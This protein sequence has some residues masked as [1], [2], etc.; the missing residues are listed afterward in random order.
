[1]ARKEY[2]SSNERSR[3]DS[4]PQLENIR[5]LIEIPIWAENYLKTLFTSTNKTGFILQMGYF[6]VT[7]R[8][9]NPHLFYEHDIN[10][11][12]E[13]F[14][15]DPNDISMIDYAHSRTSYR[16]QEEILREFSITAFS[17]EYQALLYQE[18]KRLTYLQTKPTL[19]F[20]SLVCFLQEKRIEIPTYNALREIVTKALD[21]FAKDLE[22]IIQTYL[23]EIDRDL[24]EQLA[25]KQ[26][27]EFSEKKSGYERYELTFF[28]RITQS[29]QPMQIKERLELFIALKFKYQQLQSI[30]KKLK[31]SDATIRYLADYILDNQSSQA[32]KRVNEH[33]LQLIAFVIHQYFSLGD[34]LILTLNSAVTSTFN[35]AEDRLKE[36]HYKNRFVN[37]QLANQVTR[38]STTHID[39]LGDIETIIENVQTDDSQKV[40]QIRQ[41]IVQ[42]RVK[43]PALDEDQLRLIELK[44]VNQPIS[45]RD[46]YYKSLEKESIKLQNRV[47]H[48]VVALVFDIEKSQEDI[49]KAVTYF[50]QKNGDIS[51]SNKLPIDFLSMDE[52][53]KIF[54]DS[55]KLR[56][57]LYKALLFREIKEHIKAGSLNVISCYEYRS[58]EEYL[59][60][61]NQ[62]NKHKEALLE[63]AN[64]TKHSSAAQT[65]LNLNDKL[66][67]QFMVTNDRLSEN[68]DIYFDKDGQ[69]HLHRYKAEGDN[70]PIDNRLLYP[71][72]RSIPL[73]QV[74]IQINQ[75]TGF[76]EAFQHKTEH[77]IP[78]R[79]GNN[80]FYAAIIGF[81]EN[82][83]ISEM[84]D[85]SRNIAKNTL[86]TVATHYFSPE[87]TL[88]ANDLILSMSNKLP[89]IDFFRQQSGFVHTGSDGQ[90]YDISVPSLRA[91]ASFKYFGS[92]KGITVYSHLD[93]AGQLIIST[94]FSASDREAHYL[95]NMLTY[96]E[97]I[98]PDAHSTDTH[99][100]TEPV[101]AI[102]GL[103]GIEF[104]PR[105]A[106]LYKRNLYAI[107]AVWTFKELDY[108]ISPNA[109]IDYEHLVAQWDE[110]LRM[111][112][113]IKL[114]YNKASTLFKR[115]NSYARQHPL[116]KALTDLGRLYRTDY[117]LRVIDLPSLRKSVE[118][119]LS[120][121]EHSNNLASAVTHGN[122]QQLIWASYEDQ[123]KAEGCKRLI[124]NAINYF[125]LLLLSER[126]SQCKTEQERQ[127]LLT[128]IAKSS[129]HTWRHI[130]LLG[131]YDFSDTEVSH[132]FDLKAI[133]AL[134]LTR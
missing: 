84:G 51:H 5:I 23:L 28:K 67:H 133:M 9:F 112:A 8:F 14:K 117:T 99:G 101:S 81:G 35:D 83:G 38:R 82:I 111:T 128:I 131:M 118:G 121:T 109:K 104:R 22:A 34:A 72:N 25:E 70:I 15:F 80:I 95:L 113:T 60:P 105:L 89:I 45:N 100:Y 44:K 86:E 96:N 92:G 11:V 59:I 54:T 66:N 37:A 79:P 85:I 115:L 3:F 26:K 103:I 48:I 31:L 39:A 42:K 125:N 62:W 40:E 63:K 106:G 134:K 123:L 16:H 87:M 20:D 65:L 61:R 58:F 57:S 43:K 4:P 122:N 32:L 108:K 53:Q 124:M 77:Y 10:L 29:M 24:L 130:N 21:A 64:L 126:L 55:G 114:G 129:T 6:R 52:R 132:V 71:P 12:V 90:K 93:E 17:T 76:L 18:A 78:T 2:L 30:I 91:S 119:V 41:L 116:Y 110:I 127:S 50:Q 73:L 75:L 33:Y 74:L 120:K 46:D 7:T 36:E 27:T 56:I 1:M 19:I 98:T 97:V 47:T 68:K 94:V 88:K 49:G 69:W 102:T 107:D 13:K